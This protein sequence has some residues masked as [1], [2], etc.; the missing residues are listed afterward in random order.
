MASDCKHE[1]NKWRG[2]EICDK[3]GEIKE[4]GE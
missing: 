1:Y 4:D 2:M 3:C